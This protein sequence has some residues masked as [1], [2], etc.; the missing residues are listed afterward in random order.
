MHGRIIAI[1]ALLIVAGA[2]SAKGEVAVA[3][4][5]HEIWIGNQVTIICSSNETASLF[6][7]VDQPIKANLFDF[8]AIDQLTWR[9]AYSPPLVGEY[10]IYCTNSIENSQ[11][12]QLLVKNAEISILT[13]STTVFEDE[14]LQI[15]VKL[16][17]RPSSLA[18]SDNVSFNVHVNDITLSV[19]HPFF[20]QDRWTL[21]TSVASVPAGA[22]TLTVEALLG[23]RKIAGTMNLTV[24]P[25]TEFSAKL[26]TAEVFSGQRIKATVRGLYKG[27]SFLKDTALRLYIDGEAVEYERNGETIEFTAPSRPP[28]SY[29]AVFETEF[30]G[31]VLRKTESVTYALPLRGH[32]SDIQSDT[33][34]AIEFSA[35][36]YKKTIQ[37]ASGRYEGVVKAGNYDI[38]L[39]MQQLKASLQGVE[40]TAA[41]DNF[42]KFDSFPEASI[43]GLNVAAGFA[44][45]FSL[46]FKSG[47][48]EI[49]YDASKIRNEDSLQILTCVNWNLDARACSGSWSPIAAEIDKI[50]NKVII[51]VTHFSAY[52]IGETKR[53]EAE[54]KFDRDKY[55]LNDIIK[56]TG[57]VRST[58]IF[59]GDADI[60]L[61]FLNATLTFKADSEGVFSGTLSSPD[62][63]GLIDFIFR[64]SKSN[65]EP[66]NLTRQVRVERKKE[67]ALLLPLQAEVLAARPAVFEISVINTGQTTLNNVKL[68]VS[69]LPPEGYDY[70]PKS[71]DAQLPREEK[72]SKVTVF[73][74][75]GERTAV[76]VLVSVKSD[77]ISKDDSFVLFVKK[78][79]EE[80]AQQSSGE[81]T[82][83]PV[84]GLASF[85]Q[86]TQLSS[87]DIALVGGIIVFVVLIIRSRKRAQKPAFS[88]IPLFDFGQLT[89]PQRPHAPFGR[90]TRRRARRKR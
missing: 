51:P 46:P 76:T 84:T 80:K 8:T 33:T 75:S 17:S 15:E 21:K 31:S 27:F 22:H 42:L 29:D 40:I 62:E 38:S 81:E 12:K 59:V 2:G 47:T 52:V 87:M 41:Q 48:L 72:K 66:G 16:V 23:D 83:T 14:K 19:E 58:S 73:G 26:Q 5:S 20:F 4:D 35:A 24:R 57:L 69:G 3:F 70:S 61:R 54:V 56:I 32:L 37:I 90:R 9:L 49:T 28:G 67:L 50:A 44:V 55:Y 71:W 18:I 82:F 43:E 11:K 45:E 77:E 78:Q 63:D 65:Y 60:E 6:A 30:R 36:G 53:L 64:V 25:A 74:L 68:S 79:G 39:Q 88:P 7:V 13:G 89:A 85:I 1:A 10:H 86:Q 34:G